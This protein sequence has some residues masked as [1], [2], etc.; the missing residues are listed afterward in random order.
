LLN[1]MFECLKTKQGKES[2]SI[3]STD[4]KKYRIKVGAA[5]KV[6]F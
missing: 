3:K 6:Y 5:G 4:N 2:N 1:L